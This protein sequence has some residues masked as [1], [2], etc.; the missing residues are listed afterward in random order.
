DNTQLSTI[1]VSV[2]NHT[3]RYRFG[4][5]GSSSPDGWYKGNYTATYTINGKTVYLNSWQNTTKIVYINDVAP[6]ANGEIILD[7]ST[8]ATAL[9]GF[10]AGLII[11]AYTADSMSSI[12]AVPG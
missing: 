3:R 10:N 6:D 9:Y 7:F 4:F 8:T 2:L 11:H 1:R 12:P 5:F